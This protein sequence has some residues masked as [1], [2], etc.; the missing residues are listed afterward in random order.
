MPSASS[1]AEGR[2]LPPTTRPPTCSLTPSAG[3][4]CLLLPTSKAPRLGPASPISSSSRPCS[5]NLPLRRGHCCANL[6]PMGCGHREETERGYKGWP[7]ATKNAVK[8]SCKAVIWL[9]QEC[10]VEFWSSRCTQ[11]TA[12][13]ALKV[14]E[15]AVV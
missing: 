6:C 2:G 9:G 1:C 4:R 8:I 14:E 10:F 11:A 3:K 15:A 5:K 13:M 12:E 7:E